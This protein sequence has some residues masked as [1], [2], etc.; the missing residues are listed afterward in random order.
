MAEVTVLV[1]LGGREIEMRKPTDGSL[2]V[3]SRTFRGL[4]KIENVDDIT[5]EMRE[6]L[7]R[8]LGILGQIV[9]GM[10]VKVADQD[11]LDDA[12]ISG[13]VSAEDIFGSIKLAGE[14]FNGSATA[15]VKAIKAVRRRAATR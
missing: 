11:W 8:K 12:L 10:I 2:V 15:P 14:K 4:T 1:E 5:D 9:E 3:L 7:V 13:K 6:S